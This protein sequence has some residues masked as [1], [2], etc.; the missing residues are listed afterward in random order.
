MKNGFRR[1]LAGLALLAV[2]AIAAA[3]EVERTI[4]VTGE[5]LIHITPDVAD[6]AIGVETFAATPEEVTAR[7]DAA[8]RTMLAAIR[9]QGVEE[10]HIQTQELKLEIRY[11]DGEP[12]KGVTGYLARRE[13][14]IKVTEPSRTDAIVSA[15]LSHG[16][17]LLLGVDY[18]SSDPRTYRDRARRLAV[19]AAK[20]KADLMA[21]ELDERVGRPRTINENAFNYFGSFNRL[22]A[23]SVQNAYERLD[24][25]ALTDGASIPMGQIAVQ[26]TVSVT[27]DLA[28]P[29]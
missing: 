5:A 21:A 12:Y 27:F 6:V 29:R 4:S 1:P 15:A 7:N 28:D 24:G 9:A 13:Y 20:E 8:V 22:G 17:N 2:C 18:R 25:A 16:A 3:A 23:N 26:A 19:K 14:M 10:R 11:R